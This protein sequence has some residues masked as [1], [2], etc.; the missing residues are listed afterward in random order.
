[1]ELVMTERPIRTTKLT[2]PFSQRRYGVSS[3]MFV[4]NKT[5]G[6]TVVVGGIGVEGRW[7]RVLT[8]RAAQLLWFNLTGLLFPEKAPQVTGLAVTAPIRGSDKP[9]VTYH[10]EVTR[11]AD[12]YIEVI[13]WA[14]KD[15]WWARLPEHEARHL[16]T[17]L[18]LLLYPV[19]WEGRN[20][21]KPASA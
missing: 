6:D 4:L 17:R 15:T 14:G 8:K 10:L 3:E 5:Q 9:S 11:T 19:G 12:N 7:F 16:W 1:M 21:K 13:G 20:N 2:K 18:D